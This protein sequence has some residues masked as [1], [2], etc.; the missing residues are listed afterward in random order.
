MGACE[1]LCSRRIY[2]CFL[3]PFS[4]GQTPIFYELGGSPEVGLQFT[5]GAL[6][7]FEE[8]ARVHGIAACSLGK[9]IQPGQAKG[10]QE[11]LERSKVEEVMKKH[12][13]RITGMLVLAV[14][15]A[16][17]VTRAQQAIIVNVPFEFTAGDTKLPAGEYTVG[18]SSS[19][20]PVLLIARTDRSE[21]ILVN[22]NAAQSR[23]PQTDSK[24]IFH[25]YGDRYFLSQVWS[26]GSSAGRQ[27]MKSRA[28]KE[29]ALS[30]RNGKPEEITLVA[31]LVSPK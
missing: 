14:M 25:K 2:H 27:L 30:A 28:E 16:A 7:F 15:A 4:S 22:S 10:S 26:A 5:S 18:K 9:E 29:V 24:L 13:F 3:N 11:I 12:I 17:Q 23:E 19:D 20:S 6:S 21:A 31:S 1:S 8:C